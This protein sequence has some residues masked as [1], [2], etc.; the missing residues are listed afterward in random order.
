[1]AA[2]STHDLHALAASSTHDLH[3]LAALSTHA[4]YVSLA[5]HLHRSTP[6]PPNTHQHTGQ[7]GYGVW[8]SGFRW[9]LWFPVVS[10]GCSGSGG[11]RWVLWFPVR[12]LVSS[13]FRWVIWFPVVSAGCSGFRWVPGRRRSEDSHTCVPVNGRQTAPARGGCQHLRLVSARSSCIPRPTGSDLFTHPQSTRP[14][15]SP[16][17]P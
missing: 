11:F 15:C 3:A 7:E 17:L 14:H 8:C 13:V 2:A 16:K 5:Q 10:G 6:A 4:A 1:M 9:V 12:T